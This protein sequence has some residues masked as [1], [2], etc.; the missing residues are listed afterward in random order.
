MNE[1]LSRWWTGIQ[2]VINYPL[3]E[4]GDSHLTLNTILKLLMLLA[5]VLV[6]ERY[7]RRLVRRRVLAHTHLS[8][9][10]QREPPEAG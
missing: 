6:A 2:Q 7:L 10:L 1:T 8:P 4:L 9:E 3:I 5:L